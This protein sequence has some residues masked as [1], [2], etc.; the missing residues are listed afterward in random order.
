MWKA[1][2]LLWLAEA[3]GGGSCGAS[4]F[5]GVC[6]AEGSNWLN[7]I[8]AQQLART[9]VAGGAPACRPIS[10]VAARPVAAGAIALRGRRRCVGV[11][12]AKAAKTGLRAAKRRAKRR[13]E[14][15]EAAEGRRRAVGRTK[16]RRRPTEGRAEGRRAAKGR[17]A[18]VCARG[19]GGGQEQGSQHSMGSMGSGSSAGS[20][21]LPAQDT[22]KSPLAL[23]PPARLRT[24]SMLLP[25]KLLLPTHTQCSRCSPPH[26]QCMPLLPPA[27]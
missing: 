7:C 15:R 5:G 9:R 8:A 27:P 16:E 10:A 18:E 26:T 11:R 12:R 1:G 3:Q 4:C 19:G 13:A 14:G 24:L 6:C 23:P 21:C 25:P 22:R 20:M 17:P 2:Q